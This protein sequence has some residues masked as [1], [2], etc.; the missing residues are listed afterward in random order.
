[1]AEIPCHLLMVLSNATNGRDMIQVYYSFPSGVP[2][3]DIQMETF[4]R[5]YRA[6]LPAERRPNL[7]QAMVKVVEFIKEEIVSGRIVEWELVGSDWP[8]NIGYRNGRRLS[9]E[10]LMW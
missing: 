7:L 10:M 5:K 9:A 4:G 1:M 2:Y 8:W 3:I 6:R